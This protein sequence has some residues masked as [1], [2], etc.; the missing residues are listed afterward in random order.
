M[1]IIYTRDTDEF[2]ELFE[3]ANIANRNKADLFISVHCNA[4]LNK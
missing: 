3:R 1:K 4:A 2:I